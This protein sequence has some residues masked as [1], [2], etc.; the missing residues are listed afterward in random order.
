MLGH[1]GER[2][3]SIGIKRSEQHKLLN[4]CLEA[5]YAYIGAASAVVF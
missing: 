2:M 3:K 4:A 5:I 1:S